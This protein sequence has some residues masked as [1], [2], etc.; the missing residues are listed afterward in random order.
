MEQILS[1]PGLGLELTLNPIA[2]T[3]GPLA[4][5]WYGIAFALAFLAGVCYLLSQGKR[6][7]L[8]ADRALDV[9]LGAFVAGIIGARIY[10]VAMEWEMYAA[11]P[12]SALYIWEGGIGIYGGIAAAFLFGAV[13]CKWRG[14]KLLPMM[15]AAGPALLIAQAIGRWGNFV[16]IE[17]YG[18]NTTLP[19][20]M[21]SPKI[22]AELTA[23]LPH[24]TEIG[25]VIDPSLPVHP[26]FL[27]ESL[28]NLVGF[29]LLV[30]V[31]VPRRRYDGQV[32]L[33]YAGWYGLGRFFIEGLR[34]DSLMIGAIRTSQVVALVCVIGAA[35]ALAVLSKRQHAPLYAT[36]EEGQLAVSGQLYE[37][38][39]PEEPVATEETE[40]GEEPAEEPA[41]GD[42]PELVEEEAPA[43]E[44]NQEGE[45]TDGSENH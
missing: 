43:Q 14:V 38:K 31:L 13:M 21:T 23:R 3:L 41:A 34:T 8:N 26:T 25:M 30:F 16:N 36:T 5:R 24:L 1:F 18:G 32:I 39:T 15:D 42:E 11:N 20:G 19:W 17:A 9:L 6:F 4:I 33:A 28:W 2:F 44:D 22:V 37:K 40:P 45:T 35:I 12:V 29:L 27:Y 10:Y 7:G